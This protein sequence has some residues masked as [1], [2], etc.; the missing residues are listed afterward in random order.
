MVG[1]A[2]DRAGSLYLTEGVYAIVLRL[3]ADGTIRRVAGSSLSN[4]MGDAGP[5]LEARLS[6]GGQGWSPSAVAFD[7]AGTMYLAEP[8]LNVIREVTPA[9]LALALSVGSIDWVGAGPQS[10]LIAVSTNFEEPFPYVVRVRTND[11]GGWLTVNRV[12]GQVGEALTVSLNAAGLGPGTY[13]GTV[14]VIVAAGDSP[15]VDVPVTLTIP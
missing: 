3:D 8:G 7:A 2:T 4:K 6:L 14:S 1:L 10:R 5:A 12:T 9:R 11:G 13:R 15:Q